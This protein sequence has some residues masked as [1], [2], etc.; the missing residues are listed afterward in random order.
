MRVVRRESIILTVESADKLDKSG[1]C[2]PGHLSNVNRI[3]GKLQLEQAKSSGPKKYGR[4]GKEK[5][6]SENL[7]GNGTT[8]K[9]LAGNSYQADL[10]LKFEQDVYLRDV[11]QGHIASPD[12]VKSVASSNNEC[13][14]NVLVKRGE[15]I[16]FEITKPSNQA[17]TKIH[18]LSRL[19]SQEGL[20]DDFIGRGATIAAF[21]LIVNGNRQKFEETAE[22]VRK[23]FVE[24]AKDQGRISVV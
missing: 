2:S 3:A 18:Q 16:C 6:S 1:I 10:C 9:P 15:Y 4:R 14:N 5:A 8:N 17:L 20:K 24:A 21:G 12:H 7:T 22:K 13:F 23:F 11:F 19:Y